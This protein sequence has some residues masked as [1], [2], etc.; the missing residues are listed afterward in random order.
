MVQVIYYQVN[1]N[2]IKIFSYDTSESRNF[3]ND[4][5]SFLLHITY[6]I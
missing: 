2:K 3:V 6:H 4:L 5:L 1:T